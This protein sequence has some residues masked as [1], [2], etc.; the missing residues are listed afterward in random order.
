MRVIGRHGQSG[1][2]RAGEVEVGRRQ[3]VGIDFLDDPGHEG[4][5]LAPLHSLLGP[6]RWAMP[7]VENLY[8]RAVVQ[9]LVDAVVALTARQPVRFVVHGPT[10]EALARGGHEAPLRQAGVD[11]VPLTAHHES[12]AMLQA[13]PA[14]DPDGAASKGVCPARRAHPGGAGTVSGPTA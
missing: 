3:Q 1:I 14:G 5:H 12:V 2:G 9:R 7:R 6:V 10:W 11:L 13:A 8:R 4:G